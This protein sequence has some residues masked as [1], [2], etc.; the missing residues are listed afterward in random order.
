MRAV[1]S[2]LLLALL[3]ACGGSGGGAGK[4]RSGVIHLDPR[5]RDGS[6]AAHA[7]ADAVTVIEALPDPAKPDAIGD[8]KPLHGRVE[9]GERSARLIGQAQNPEYARVVCSKS[10]SSGFVRGVEVLMQTRKRCNARL[11]WTGPDG[12]T[13]LALDVIGG[14]NTRRLFFQLDARPDWRGTISDLTLVPNA[15]EGA[16]VTIRAIRIYSTGFEWGP[17]PLGAE[18]TKGGT[19][20]DSG[21]RRRGWESRR[22]WPSDAGVPL[23]DEV[24]DVPRGG[25]LSIAVALGNAAMRKPEG[26]VCVVDA[27]KPGGTWERLDRRELKRAPN[28]A[29]APW[30]RFAVDLARHAGS[31]L[32]LRFLATDGEPPAAADF[33]DE[34]APAPQNEKVLWGAPTVVGEMPSDRRPN[35]VLIT[36][37]TTRADS[38]GGEWTRFLDGLGEEGIVFESA[39]SPCNSTTASH[40]SILTGLHVEDHGALTNRHILSPENRTLAELFR[41]AGYYTAAVVSVPHIQAGTGLGQG[42]DLFGLA[43]P[44]ADKNG[45]FALRRFKLF[46]EEWDASPDRPLFLWLHL[47][48]PHTPYGPPQEWVDEFVSE[49]GIEPPPM[50]ANPPT[51]PVYARSNLTEPPETK[52]WLK[53]ATSVEYARYLY[54]LGVAYADF[55]CGEAFKELE[56]RDLVDSTF[57]AVTADHGEALGEHGVFFN[58]AGL[59]RA[60]LN[61]PMIVKGPGV[62]QGQRVADPVSGLDVVPTLLRLCAIPEP[63]GLRGRDLLETARNGGEPGRPIWFAHNGLHQVGFHDGEQ[64][65]VTTLTSQLSLGVDLVDVDGYRIPRGRP[66]IPKG[67]SF[68]Y[69]DSTDAYHEV[70]LAAERK[71]D[72]QAALAKVADWR[73]GMAKARVMRR[74]LT[75]EEEAELADLG[76]AGD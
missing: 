64:H 12:L 39:W 3:C 15:T 47:F 54:D 33:D 35:V 46:M 66:P 7:L 71:A 4:P 50:M 36:L 44:G 60:T 2:L 21:L 58:H 38:F 30:N 42:F 51:V 67:T 18:V 41:R 43:Q 26:L 11:Q 68:L 74:T 1:S 32:E 40:A 13:G 61:V 34:A 57:F 20:G 75:A 65:F 63:P 9:V 31:P 8:W 45:V 76:Y 25:V 16:P 73:A 49:S 14:E 6:S 59:Y 72:V 22:A 62:P 52:H 29:S 55:L 19:H 17:S 27:R 69:D 56:Q 37:D 28:V 5:L 70:D 53:G 23:Y 48:D 24:E 10:F